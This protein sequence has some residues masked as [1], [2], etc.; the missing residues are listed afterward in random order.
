MGSAAACW[1]FSISAIVV[2]AYF[3]YNTLSERK[4]SPQMSSFAFASKPLSSGK[5][6]T[7]FQDG[8][9][10]TYAAVMSLLRDGNE[11]FMRAFL[12]VLKNG[13]QV[14]IMI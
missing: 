9:A 2:A 10:L 1:F 4:L 8:S 14:W 5:Q 12:D 13:I 3:A 11:P 7:A 6:F